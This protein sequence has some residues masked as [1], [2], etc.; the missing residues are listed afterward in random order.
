MVITFLDIADLFQV[1]PSGAASDAVLTPTTSPL[2]AGAS[3]GVSTSQSK[4]RPMPKFS[5]TACRTTLPLPDADARGSVDAPE[6]GVPQG[7]R[8]RDNSWGGGHLGRGHSYAQLAPL[9]E[10]F[11]GHYEAPSR[12]YTNPN[13]VQ[14]QFVQYHRLSR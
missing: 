8:G 10:H 6:E 5:S 13:A 2:P 12:F 4:E 1:P 7:A 9:Q 3:G 11:G 14:E